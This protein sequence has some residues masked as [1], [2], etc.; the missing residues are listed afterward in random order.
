MET[1]VKR[2][3]LVLLISLIG[4]YKQKAFWLVDVILLGIQGI[5]GI[6]VALM[7]FF[8]DVLFR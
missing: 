4:W 3:L 7:F 6:I 1:H 2:V 8:S 5:A